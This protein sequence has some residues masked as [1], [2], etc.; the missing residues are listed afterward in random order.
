MSQAQQIKKEPKQ[1]RIPALRIENK[2]NKWVRYSF[3]KYKWHEEKWS[4]KKCEKVGCNLKQVAWEGYIWN[5]K[6]VMKQSV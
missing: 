5:S 6:Y 1:T 3:L 4:S 2:K